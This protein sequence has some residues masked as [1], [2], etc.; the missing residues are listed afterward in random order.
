MAHCVCLDSRNLKHEEVIEIDW[1]VLRH[2]E[3][4]GENSN[5]T[6]ESKDEWH[7]RWSIDSFTL[8]FFLYIFE[9]NPE[10]H[11]TVSTSII[12]PM[13]NIM[14]VYKEFSIV[15]KSQRGLLVPKYITMAWKTA[16][17]STLI[18]IGLVL[19]IWWKYKYWAVYVTFWFHRIH[20]IRLLP[21]PLPFLTWSV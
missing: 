3:A 5:K 15:K 12:P 17:L 1:L 13:M 19:V 8:I 2:F 11:V 16:R 20:Y 10:C 6:L 7:W 14:S 4:L 18:A 21:F 9:N